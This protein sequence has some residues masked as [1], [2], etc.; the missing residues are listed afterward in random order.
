MS[1]WMKTC[2][3]NSKTYLVQ[4]LGV[5]ENLRLD[6]ERP[7]K[8]INVVDFGEKNQSIRAIYKLGSSDSNAYFSWRQFDD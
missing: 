4:Y 1:K 5:S 6:N 7:W 3:T 2:H 8:E